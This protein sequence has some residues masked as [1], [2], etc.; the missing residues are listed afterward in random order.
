MDRKKEIFRLVFSSKEYITVNDIAKS[1][2]ISAKTVRNDLLEL[3]VYATNFRCEIVK[4]PGKGVSY[5]GDLDNVQKLMTSFD[6]SKLDK[7]DSPEYRQQRILLKLFNSQEATLIK[8]LSIELH[9]SRATINKDIIILNQWLSSYNLIIEYLKSK[10]VHIVGSENDK[11]NAMAMVFSYNQRGGKVNLI[12][13]HDSKVIYT[14]AILNL[15]KVLGIDFN[16]LIAMIHRVERGFGNVFSTEATVTLAMNLAVIINR[17]KNGHRILLD[18][19]L[20]NI[21]KGSEELKIIEELVENVKNEFNITLPE[22]ERYYILLH[23]LGAKVLKNGIIQPLDMKINFENEEIIREFVEKIQIDIGLFLENDSKLIESLMLHIKPSINR[24]LYGLTLHNPL[25]SEIKR[26]YGEIFRIVSKHKSIIDDYF[27][28]KLPEDEIAYLVL[29]FVVSVERSSKTIRILIACAS[30]IGI[31]QLLAVKI[32]RLFKN[33]EIVAVI[34]IYEIEKY[35]HQNIDL[36]ISTVDTEENDEFKTIVVNPLLSQNDIISITDIIN[37]NQVRTNLDNLFYEEN[38]Y[39][40]VDLDSKEEVLK[41]AYEKLMIN[42]YVREY[43]YETLIGREKK[44]ST[45]IGNNV[46]VVH[47]DMSEVIFNCLQIIKLK[48]PILWNDKDRVDFIINVVCTKKDSIYFTKVFRK[49]G[50]YL[51]DIDFWNRIKSANT[52]KEMSKL[53]NKELANDY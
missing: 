43:Y 31:S 6:N 21:L 20:V 33:I 46:A 26:D 10:G 27:H 45:Y 38:I 2:G 53:L 13:Y 51:D 25:L 15:E 14:D 47:G 34:S 39:L 40:N 19:E 4:I 44:G 50:N 9:V 35:K 11:R 49:L 7:I 16:K 30:G 41:F 37:H 52:S 23:F 29:H 5:V 17:A 24:I 48:Q 22:P 42:H 12:T 28:I 3:E 36:L 32:E 8:Q 1:L 18:F